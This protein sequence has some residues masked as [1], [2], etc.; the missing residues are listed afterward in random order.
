MNAKIA[1]WD[2]Y[3]VPI[4]IVDGEERRNGGR[5]PERDR[6]GNGT[7]ATTSHVHMDSL[8]RPAN[9]PSEEADRLIVLVPVYNDWTAL[10]R[11]LPLLD[12]ALRPLDGAVR[13]VVDDDGSTEPE[14][15]R[16]SSLPLSRVNWVTIVSLRR[17][18][19]HQRAI[20]MGL[21]HIEACL[22]CRCVVVMDGDGEDDPQDVMR[23]VARMDELRSTAVVFA[24]RTRRIDGI[25]FR[26]FYLLYRMLHRMLTGIPVRVGNFSAIPAG[27]L[28]RLV[29]VSEVW[30][31]YAA[32]VFLAR[33]PRA[34]IPSVRRPRLHGL[35][36]M[37]V[38]SLVGHG[39]SGLSVHAELVGV[40]LLVAGGV[41]AAVVLLLLAGLAVFGWSTGA[42]WRHAPESR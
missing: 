19:G 7:R 38:V 21:A 41:V 6:Q 32:A 37:N 42:V 13:V 25:A 29:V 9:P 17:N 30:N 14:D 11:L 28:R 3:S 33:I 31:H 36:K 10:G 12:D 8:S 5:A 39:L 24:E 20:A 2:V 26:L 34:T 15:G 4:D 27:M 23:L 22:P 16:V 40:R 1:G 18:M 35:S